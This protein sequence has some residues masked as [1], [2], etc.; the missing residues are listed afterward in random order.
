IVDCHCH[1]IPA[2]MT[3]TA[4]PARWRPRLGRNEDGRQSVLLRG[5]VTRS[6]IG[7]FTDVDA[8]LGEAAAQGV[9]HLLLSPWIMLV[10]T[11]AEPAE[12]REVC[13]VQNAALSALAA[14]RLAEVTVLGAVPLADP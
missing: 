8:M 1:V 13:R 3:T 4:V 6:I 10:P 5:R 12:C 2:E 14:A 7:E 9:D 11:D